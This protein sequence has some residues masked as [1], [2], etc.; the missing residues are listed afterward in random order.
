MLKLKL[1]YFA[2]LMWTTYSEKPLLLGKIEGRRRGRQRMRQL[3]GITDSLQ[4]V[5]ASSRNWWW[6]GK[7]GVLQ[8]MGL[9]RVG[10]DWATEVKVDFRSS[11]SVKEPACQCRRHKHCGSNPSVGKIP[12]RRAWQPTPGFLPR[13]SHGQRSLEGYSPQGHTVGHD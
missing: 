2:Q 6:T 1:Q 8:S 4:W 3:D 9:Q 12:W 11:A 5:W 13:E 10:L 7:P